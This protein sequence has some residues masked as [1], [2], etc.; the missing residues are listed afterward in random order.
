[1]SAEGKVRKSNTGTP[2]GGIIS[3]LL[4]NIGLTVLDKHFCDKCDA[5]GTRYRRE[6]H[7]NRGW[8]HVPDHPLRG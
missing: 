3:P 6:A 7:R 4:A 5:H 8:G 1:M 2:Q